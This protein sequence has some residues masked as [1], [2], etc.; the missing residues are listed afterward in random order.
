MGYH[1][2]G[3]SVNEPMTGDTKRRRGGITETYMYE[4][5]Y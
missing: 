4:Q 3:E 1:F 5:V 2:S